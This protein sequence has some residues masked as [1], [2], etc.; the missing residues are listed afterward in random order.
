[1]R[2]LVRVSEEGGGGR[3]GEVCEDVEDVEMRGR[4]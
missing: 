1:M 3:R 2:G 4:M